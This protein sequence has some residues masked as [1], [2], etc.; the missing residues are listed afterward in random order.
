VD[1]IQWTF[2]LGLISNRETIVN[3]LPG[4][5]ITAFTSAFIMKVAIA[6]H[7]RTPVKTTPR[8]IKYSGGLLIISIATIL[9]ELIII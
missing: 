6:E 9:M 2:V 8:T 3:L 7:L 4:A 5:I 1:V